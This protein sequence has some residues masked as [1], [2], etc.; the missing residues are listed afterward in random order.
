M[1]CWQPLITFHEVLQTDGSLLKRE[2]RH[3]IASKNHGNPAPHK[4]L[5]CYQTAGLH[6]MIFYVENILVTWQQ[7]P[8][9][10]AQLQEQSSL[11]DRQ[12][13]NCCSTGCIITCQCFETHA[14]DHVVLFNTVLCRAHTAA[15][16]PQ[17]AMVKVYLWMKLKIKNDGRVVLD[18]QKQ[19]NG[20]TGVSFF[21]FRIR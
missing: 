6:R 18:F 1:K 5:S 14:T 21:C 2:T 9:Y 16:K 7:V 8:R 15:G 12:K 3:N 19:K 20:T 10:S 17:I 4:S 13:T 11:P